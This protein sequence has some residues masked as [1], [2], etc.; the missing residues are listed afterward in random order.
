MRLDFYSCDIF[1]VWTRLIPFT[2]SCCVCTLWIICT[3]TRRVDKDEE[4]SLCLR[5]LYSCVHREMLDSA[6][7]GT[8]FISLL[9]HDEA[10]L[11]TSE[12]AF[13]HWTRTAH[14]KYL[15][16]RVLLSIMNVSLPSIYR[17]I[18]RVIEQ[19][20]FLFECE[21]VCCACLLPCQEYWSRGNLHSSNIATQSG[22]SAH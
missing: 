5:P 18:Y 12:I 9:S 4:P 21:V 20:V 16:I 19:R 10:N 14:L 1:G 11:S 13:T 22:L 17:V 8:D 6:L 15:L 2:S 3:T 7:S